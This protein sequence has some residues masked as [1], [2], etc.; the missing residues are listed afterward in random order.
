MEIVLFSCDCYL[1]SNK[2]WHVLEARRRSRRS[3][4]GYEWVVKM[5]LVEMGARRIGF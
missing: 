3:R 1:F 2:R 5:K 4:S